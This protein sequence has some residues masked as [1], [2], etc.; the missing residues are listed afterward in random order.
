MAA[1]LE[2]DRISKR[3]GSKLALDSLSLRV[4]PGEILGFLGPNGAGKTTAIHLA[5]GFLKASAGSGTLLGS[6]LGTASARARLGYL[7][8]A[9]AFFASSTAFQVELAARL[10]GMRSS[11][12]KGRVRQLL[13]RLGVE[14]VKDARKLSRGMQQRLGLARALVNEPEL[15]ILDEPTSALDPSAVSQV[16]ELLLIARNE[17][18]SIFFSSHQLSEVEQVCDRIAFLNHGRLVKLGSLS[19]LLH[20]QALAEVVVRGVTAGQL[21]GLFAE[22]LPGGQL[23]ILIPQARQREVIERIW[24]A[25]GELISTAPRRRTLEQLFAEWSREP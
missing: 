20:D 11:E 14:S 16:R 15:L 18:H 22:A 8:D 17:G 1:R 7:P 5:L 4:E 12:I 25:G 9:P 21:E 2:F 10:N 19:E 23:R 13:S 6:P 24:M 3:F